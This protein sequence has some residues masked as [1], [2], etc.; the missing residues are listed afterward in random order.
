MIQTSIAGG[1]AGVAAASGALPP[2][3]EFRLAGSITVNPSVTTD[4]AI[5]ASPNDIR[6]IGVS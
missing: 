5:A 2:C 1:T 6:G 3:P 4:R